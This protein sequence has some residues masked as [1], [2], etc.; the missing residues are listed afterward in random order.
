MAYNPH[1]K[2]FLATYEAI[3]PDDFSALYRLVQ[4][5][6]RDLINRKRPGI[7]LGLAEM[8]FNRGNFIGGL[9]YAGTNHIYL[10]KS[11]LRVMQQE[12]SPELY[13]AF[14][15]FLL[16]HEYTHAV[17]VQDER[18]TRRLTEK[19]VLTVFPQDHPVTGLAVKGLAVY[20]P[21]TFNQRQ[22]RPTRQELANTEYV[23]IHHA[24]SE[25][26]YN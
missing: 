4:D 17:G 19:M 18:L 21:Y 5:I 26:T 6:V 20:F 9:H 16:L 1:Y 2:Y 15:L 25:M 24:D 12:S 13:K 14:V 8:G 22:H 3:H 7:I 10:N 11:A 23:T